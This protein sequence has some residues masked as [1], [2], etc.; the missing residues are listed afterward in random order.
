MDPKKV[1]ERLKSLRGATS[2]SRMAK[3][4]GLTKQALC[5]Y[6]SGRRVPRDETKIIIARYFGRSVQEI[7]FD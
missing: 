1:A 4:T 5:N 3:A 2:L 6:E 7:F